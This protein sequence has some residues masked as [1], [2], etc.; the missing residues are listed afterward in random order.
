MVNSASIQVKTSPLNPSTGSSVASLSVSEESSFEKHLSKFT[1]EKSDKNR[2]AQSSVSE[3][4]EPNEGAVDALE[5]NV[6]AAPEEG[7]KPAVASD[8]L[9]QDAQTAVADEEVTAEQVESTD[10]ESTDPESAVAESIDSKSASLEK[11]RVDDLEVEDLSDAA[12]KEVVAQAESVDVNGNVDDESGN[13]L[14][15]DE[16]DAE[17]NVSLA[18]YAAI[19]SAITDESEEQ[20]A[21]QNQAVSS[22]TYETVVPVTISGEGRKSEGVELSS[23]SEVSKGVV[24]N[25]TSSVGL[26]QDT[27][28]NGVTTSVSLAEKLSTAVANSAAP[29]KNNE[30]GNISDASK[31]QELLLSEGDVE[32]SES[33]LE[34]NNL[35][36]VISQIKPSNSNQ[37]NSVSMV[38]N[39]ANLTQGELTLQG[40][41]GELSE[42]DIMKPSLVG[43]EADL[44]SDKDLE[45]GDLKKKEL[46]SNLAKLFGANN[47]SDQA[48]NFGNNINSVAAGS[49]SSNRVPSQSVPNFVM[50]NVPTSPEWAGEMSQKVSI[51][52]ADGI[53]TAHIHLDPPELGSL[54]VKVQV[55]HD[56]NAQVSFVAS[57]QMARDAIESQLSRL[58]EMLA[59]QGMNLDNVDVDVSSGDGSQAGK[60]SAGEGGQGEG[61]SGFAEGQEELD[62]EDIQMYDIHNEKQGIDYYA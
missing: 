52:K 23:N 47:E 26:S 36:W 41:E 17:E 55:D 58:R 60:A 31:G 46:D 9:P 14:H 43:S 44:L 5:K 20:A 1:S 3:R 21:L 7:Q 19:D 61:S 39:S 12:L 30:L 18:Q 48:A 34:S 4:Q 8:Q 22:A 33:D 59:Q 56:G 40:Q 27:Q 38:S 11:N 49:S 54:T 25:A 37:S 15:A 28:L 62:G 53:K 57:S 32:S 6:N 35:N 13:A 45:A 51:L 29:L 50:S 10:P 24:Q 2:D 16:S 42:G